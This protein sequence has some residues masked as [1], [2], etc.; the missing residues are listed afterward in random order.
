MEVVVWPNPENPFPEY[1]SGDEA[2]KV[3]ETRF[4]LT[5]V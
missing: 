3:N 1:L 4:R 2:Q 5:K